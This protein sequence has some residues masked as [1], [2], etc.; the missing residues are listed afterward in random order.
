MSR[1]YF[2]SPTETV[3]LLGSERAHLS[4]FAKDM[5]SAYIG[6]HSEDNLRALLPPGH[7]LA[8]VEPGP[9]FHM[10]YATCLRTG[11]EL[12]QF[13]GRALQSF[14]L[15]LN[16]AL[17]LGNDAVKLAARIDGQCEIHGWV[18][19]PN[20]AWLAGI[21]SN[22]LDDGLYRREVQGHPTGWQDVLRLLMQRDDE[23]VVMSYSVCD[24]FPNPVA[25]G[26][27][28]DPE[29]G[30]D[31]DTFADRSTEEQWA[32]SMPALR[33]ETRGLELRPDD[34]QDFR[35][36][37]RLSMRDLTR[38]DYQGRIRAALGLADA[39]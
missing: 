20:R 8:P 17:Q 1:I 32:R 39:A 22:A 7:H 26:F 34:W 25:A 23:P 14:A 33:D 28:I 3:E 38:D 10:W 31:W 27:E 16:T 37:H 11:D 4:A 15:T 5:A 30:A 29:W 35:F 6:P 2:H 36:E 12:A 13:D 19:G 9:T 24:S 21:I 18:D